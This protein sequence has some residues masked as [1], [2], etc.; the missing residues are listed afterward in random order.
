MLKLARYF[1]W[2]YEEDTFRTDPALMTHTPQSLSTGCRTAATAANR[3]LPEEALTAAE[4]QTIR[5]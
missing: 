5:R 2:E 3:T 1:D 4:P